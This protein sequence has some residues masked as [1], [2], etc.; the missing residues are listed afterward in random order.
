MPFST[1]CISRLG[2]VERLFGCW[3]A[4][5]PIGLDRLTAWLIQSSRTAS[6]T[7]SSI[8]FGVLLGTPIAK[9]ISR[10]MRVRNRDKA[11]P[12]AKSSESG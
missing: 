5:T 2:G 1:C 3:M 12:S 4:C 7:T 11:N 10:S 9:S 8:F 6:L